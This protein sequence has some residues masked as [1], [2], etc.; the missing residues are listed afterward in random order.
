MAQKIKGTKNRPRFY[1]FRSHKHIYAQIIDDIENRTLITSSSISPQLREQ[2]KSCSNCDAAEIIG[3]DIAI[4]SIK[5]GIHKVIFDR[6]GRMYHG[7]VKALAN[8]AREA[9]INF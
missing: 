2:I 7:R 4:K 8:A 3:R 5:Q 1:V 9:G 6:G